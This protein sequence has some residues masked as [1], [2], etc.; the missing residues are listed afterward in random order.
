L[1]SEICP[2]KKTYSRSATLN[3]EKGQ[4]GNDARESP[5]VNL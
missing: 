4:E 1:S 3:K 5:A 2:Q